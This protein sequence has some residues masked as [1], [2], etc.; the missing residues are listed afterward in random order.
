[1]INLLMVHSFPMI[2]HPNYTFFSFQLILQTLL[3]NYL[4][5]TLFSLLLQFHYILDSILLLQIQPYL[6]L[7][8][9]HQLPFPHLL[10]TLN[11]FILYLF[12]TLL[13]R[14]QVTKLIQT[15]VQHILMV[16]LTLILF[17]NSTS[18]CFSFHL[19]IPQLH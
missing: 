16:H 7:L 15:S 5:P 13:P 11:L 10:F 8:S 12:Q 2:L 3:L 6:I 18:I 17:V 9:L 19:H 1:M 14:I 4:R